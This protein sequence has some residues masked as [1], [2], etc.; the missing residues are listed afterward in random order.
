MKQKR[1]YLVTATK[2]KTEEEFKRRPIAKSLAKLC[3]IYDNWSFEF[4]VVKDNKEGLSSVY[5]RYLNEDH[6]NDIILFV[7]DDVIIDTLFLVEHLRKSPYTVTGLAGTKS[8]NLKADK[9]AWHLMGERKDFLGEVR[10]IKDGS[11]WCT[12]FGPTI[13]QVAALDGLFIAVNVEQILTTGARF[14][15][16]FNFHHY[17]IAFALECQ[18]HN[19][20]MGVMPINVIHYG[21]G[22]SMLTQDWEESN[23]KFKE[24]YCL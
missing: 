23:K 17:D 3:E 24:V 22:D 5:N 4:D 8:L 18:K 1:V 13:G 11:V 19:V 16:E 6:K 7:H 12:T 2:A 20:T 15:E 21:L 9:T 14:N 10:H